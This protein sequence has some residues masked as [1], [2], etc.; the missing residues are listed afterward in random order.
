VRRRA[1]MLNIE[2]DEQV[3][4]LLATHLTSHARELTGAMHQLLAISRIRKEPITRAIAEEALAEMIQQ[5]ARPI[6]LNEIDKAVCDVFGLGPS[7]LQVGR[8]AKALNAPRMLAMWL[9]CKHTRAALSEIGQYFGRR[10]HSTVI[11]AQK[12]VGRW[13]AEQAALRM[14]DKQCN[15]EDAIRRVEARLKAV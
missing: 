10:S 13:L 14:G 12:M 15:T 8:R 2:L 9:A 7:S 3:Q 1:A 5:R 11:S 6:R 4:Q